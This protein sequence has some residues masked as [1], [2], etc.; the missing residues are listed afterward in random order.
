MGNFSTGDHIHGIDSARRE[1]THSRVFSVRVHFGNIS[2]WNLAMDLRC[3]FI[4]VLSHMR[5]VGPI[6]FNC[7]KIF[8]IFHK[9][10]ANGSQGILLQKLMW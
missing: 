7:P 6:L 1:Y 8:D 5:C 4:Y 3:S 2:Q 10:I 9:N